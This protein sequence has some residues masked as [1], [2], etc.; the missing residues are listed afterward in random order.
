MQ[1]FS[2]TITEAIDA[3]SAEE[4]ALLLYQKLFK[5]PPPLTYAVTD[6]TARTTDITLD[7][8]D[9][10]EFAVADHTADPGNW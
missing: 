2:V 6:Q 4:A 9:A 3:D 10:R 1:K 5:G 8:A 7:Q